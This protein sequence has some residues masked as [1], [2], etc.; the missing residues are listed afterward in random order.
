MSEEVS[1]L[2]FNIEKILEILPHRYPFLMI[3]CILFI[4]TEEGKIVGRK[5]VSINEHFFQGH[6]PKL[7][8]MP[9]VLIIEAIAQTGAVLLHQKGYTEE[10][11]LLLTINHAKF[12][13]SVHPGD[14]LTLTC[15]GPHFSQRGGKIRGKA[16]V[17]Q[18]VVA[19]A[20]I[21]F[22]LTNRFTREKSVEAEVPVRSIHPTAIIEPGATLGKHVVIEPYAV[23]K[24]NVTLEDQVTIKS[25]AYI[26][27]YTTIKEGTT[28]W[29]FASIGTKT[30]DLKYKG[31]KTYVVIGKNCEIREHTQ[32]NSSAGEGSTVTIGNHCLI[33]ASCHVAH[34]CTL[35]D[36][37]IL[38]GG[39]KIAGH[40][41]IEK[42]AIIGGLTGI[43][44]FCRIGTLAMVGGMSGVAYDI[45]PY[46]LAAG[47][48]CKVG[49]INNVGLQRNHFS[50]EQRMIL[51]EAFKIVYKSGL[52]LKAALK[53]IEETFT[54]TEEIVHWLSF[55]HHS[56][57]G[58]TGLQTASPQAL[59]EGAQ[60]DFD[61][62]PFESNYFF[63]QENSS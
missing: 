50:Y 33:M 63:T 40:V 42:S 5:N 22:A 57:R 12:R 27:G 60:E 62:V 51:N 9:G 56:K 45:A 26:D 48:P 15:E 31:E 4:D 8:V 13:R 52:S 6:F 24:K 54:Q 29:P 49:G 14:T 36:H 32:I 35:E 46:V 2:P 47:N 3:D 53:K 7:P 38:S 37:V 39:A 16:E 17:N 44:Q 28:I 10:L 1:F 19:E 18:K 34:E 21:G 25:H 41:Y 59:Q 11:A 55:F 20:E 23:V 30:Q 58:L 43:H 61:C